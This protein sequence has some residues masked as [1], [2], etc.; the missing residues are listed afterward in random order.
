MISLIKQIK[1][2]VQTSAPVVEELRGPSLTQEQLDKLRTYKVKKENLVPCRFMF[3][4]Q[5]LNIYT[6]KLDKKGVNVMYQT[7]YWNFDT[8]L[9]RMIKQEL[10]RDV[11]IKLGDADPALLDG[12]ANGLT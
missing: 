4:G 7:H 8:K 6:G 11:M 1:S 9:A 3:K 12:T 5:A 2:T 10:G